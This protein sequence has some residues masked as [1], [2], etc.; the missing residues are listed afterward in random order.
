M[1]L[2]S[3]EISSKISSMRVPSGSVPSFRN[4]LWTM[5]KTLR[6][7]P[8]NGFLLNH[9]RSTRVQNHRDRLVVTVRSNDERKPHGPIGQ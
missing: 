1:T 5:R 7:L 3:A 8:E 4:W 6:F 9:A 2:K